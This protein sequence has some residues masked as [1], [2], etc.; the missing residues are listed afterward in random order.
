MSLGSPRFL[1][2][3]N[4]RRVATVL[5]GF[6]AALMASTGRTAA[7][8]RF[9]PEL[10]SLWMRYETA[11]RTARADDLRDVF[12][13]HA[14]YHNITRGGGPFL[15]D[16]PTIIR[17]HA[18]LF[19]SITTS[20]AVV[21]MR[22]HSVRRLADDS[23]AVVIGHFQMG[24]VN[25]DP[26]RGLVGKILQVVERVPGG[27]WRIALE[28][29]GQLAAGAA[30]AG[31]VLGARLSE[32]GAWATP[33]HVGVSDS[34]LASALA[35]LADGTGRWSEFL[36]DSVA[37]LLAGSDGWRFGK[38]GAIWPLA[39]LLGDART[40]ATTVPATAE[41]RPVRRWRSIGLAVDAGY[42]QVKPRGES[43]AYGKYVAVFQR[44]LTGGW[45]LIAWSVSPAPA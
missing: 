5:I 1:A 10:D 7:A 20:G 37:M 12:G 14:A 17:N 9:I 32:G 24:Q 30:A 13:T 2:R 36:A 3:N 22:L 18:S 31:T 19:Q 8:Q 26:S 43:P 41:L 33:G 45:E 4:D 35:S 6:V 34:S 27:G 42:V 16:Q 11:W 28:L 38:V 40:S 25:G 44:R 29:N 21:D 39:Y 15:F 23:L